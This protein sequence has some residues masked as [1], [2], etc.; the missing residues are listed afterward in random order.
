LLPR[1]VYIGASGGYG[2]WVPRWR[3]IRWGRRAGDPKD[4]ALGARVDRLGPDWHI[5]DWPHDEPAGEIDTAGFV[6]IG[7]GGVYVTTVLD[8]GR[9]RLLIAGDLVQFDGKRPAYVAEVRRRARRAQR[10]L[11]AAA[12]LAVP[13][14]PLLTVAGS[15]LLSVHG[16]PKKVLV[17]TT[18]ELDRLLISGGARITPATAGRLAAIADHPATWAN[19]PYRP[20]RYERPPYA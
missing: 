2:G 5:V 6:I 18:Q 16:L 8:H 20:D 11:S 12:G 17:A 15:G 14:T 10:A 13:V 3:S 4:H 19:A 1:S 9:S 7:P